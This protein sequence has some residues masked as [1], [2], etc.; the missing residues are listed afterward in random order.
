MA[1][2]ETMIDLEAEYDARAYKELEIPRPPSVK[3]RWSGPRVEWREHT[4][5]WQEPEIS[6]RN[7]IGDCYAMVADAV[8]TQTQPFPG[9]ELYASDNLIPELRFN[10]AKHY[11]GGMYSIYD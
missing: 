2:E 7:Q 8:L 11:N 1:F 5:Y 6:A 10:V 3:V 9:D 4:P